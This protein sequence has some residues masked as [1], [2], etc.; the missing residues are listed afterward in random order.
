MLVY[1]LDKLDK[2]EF[3]ILNGL[4]EKNIS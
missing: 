1:T 3:N 2:N 4:A